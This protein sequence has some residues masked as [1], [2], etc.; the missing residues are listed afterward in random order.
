MATLWYRRIIFQPHNS[1]LFSPLFLGTVVLLLSGVLLGGCTQRSA[2]QD[3]LRME[4]VL[5]AVVELS[6]RAE[7]D[8]AEDSAANAFEILR[9]TLNMCWEIDRYGADADL[10]HVIRRGLPP[11]LAADEGL[12]NALTGASASWAPRI[13]PENF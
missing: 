4:R 11:S 13:C 2:S 3:D 5:D 9:L 6:A 12:V 7:S 10:S 1:R 8:G